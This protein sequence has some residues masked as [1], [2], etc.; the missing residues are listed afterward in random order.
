M[1]EVH[2]QRSQLI[3]VQVVAGYSGSTLTIPDQPMLRNKRV[4]RIEAYIDQDMPLSLVTGNALN[5][6]ASLLNTGLIL[7]CADPENEQDTGEYVYKMPLVDLRNIQDPNWDNYAPAVLRFDD[8]SVQWEKTQLVFAASPA[9]IQP[10]LFSFVLNVY[11]TSRK[12]RLWKSLHKK[13]SGISDGTIADAVMQKIHYLD[14]MLK[15]ILE[16][17][18]E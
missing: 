10:T 5:T 8:L 17:K 16:G 12:E 4:T 14:Q 11:Y 3:D 13:L 18:K 9:G 1:G 7:Y 6:L 2:F 15:K